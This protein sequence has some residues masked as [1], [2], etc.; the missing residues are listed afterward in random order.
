MH[1]LSLNPN[2]A[3]TNMIDCLI[4]GRGHQYFIIRFLQSQL[5]D[6]F[7]HSGGLTGAGRAEQQVR[8]FGTFV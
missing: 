7:D 1:I 6:Q 3:F 5:V 2:Q 4:A 8:R